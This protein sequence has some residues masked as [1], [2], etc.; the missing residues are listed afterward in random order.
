M[1]DATEQ[2]AFN[3][4]T[5]L[6]L[7]TNYEYYRS[8]E[9]YNQFLCNLLAIIRTTGHGVL[10]NENLRQ[11]ETEEIIAII[12]ATLCNTFSITDEFRGESIGCGLYLGLAKHDHACSSTS[13]VIF[14][15]GKAILRAPTGTKYST[16]ITISY[17]SRMLPTFKRQ[18][19]ISKVHFF[20]CRCDLC[21]DNMKD[22]IGLARVCPDRACSGYCKSSE[23]FSEECVVCGKFPT[24][25]VDEAI[26]ATSSLIDELENIHKTIEDEDV[27]N[28][29]KSLR[30]EYEKILGPPNLSLLM[31]DEAIAFRTGKDDT[32]GFEYIIER[33]G[34]GAPETSRR[35][36]ISC[37]ARKDDDKL[38]TLAI[39]SCKLSHG[40]SHP[41]TVGII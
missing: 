41:L 5:F 40:E 25:S 8:D 30:K 37:K 24:I 29:L 10:K 17:V 34:I 31:L 16:R 28:Y 36:F 15:G 38:R 14:N 18:E 39:K 21:N 22:A 27:P 33:L 20:T 35:L 2:K 4:S 7:E 23:F 3:G 32:N 13:F 6:D 26:E 9:K 19:E 1:S 12:C 11:I